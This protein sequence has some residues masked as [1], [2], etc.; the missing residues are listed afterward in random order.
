MHRTRITIGGNLID[1]PNKTYTSTA[2][3][4]TVKVLLN[5]I[6]ST[7]GAKFFTIDV[8]NFYLQHP[9]NKPEYLQIS[10][11]LF[12][13]EVIDYYNL[14]TLVDKNGTIYMQI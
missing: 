7:I 12:P 2:E 1:Y 14:D 8:K 13:Q 3:M 9:L 11:A 5:S 4:T 10:L 6:I